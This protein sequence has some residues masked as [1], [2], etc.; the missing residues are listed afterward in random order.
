MSGKG[1]GFDVFL[2]H[3]SA[4]GR[5]V[6]ELAD[7]LRAR[8]LRPWLD[9]W[10]LVPGADWQDGLA[11]GLRR[12][13]S[14]AVFLGRSAL[15]SWQRPEVKVA[16]DRAAHD[17]SFRVFL[18]LLPGTPEPFDPTT[19][20]PFLR[21][22]TWVDLR[23]GPRAG[24]GLVDRLVRA[25]QGLPIDGPNGVAQPTGACPYRGLLPFGESDSQWF[26]GRDADVQRL[27]EKLK[28]SQFLAVLGPSGSGKSSVTMA[29]L[30]P[31]L[32][33][34]DVPGSH[35][36]AYVTLTPGPRPLESLVS[37]LLELRP[38]LPGPTVL[39]ELGASD[40]ALSLRLGHG[41]RRL[42]VT[43]DQA[44]EVFTLG[45]DR[46]TVE[47]FFGNLLH[48]SAPGGPCT[49]IL[50]MRADYY[51]RAATLPALAQTLG[52]HQYLVGPLDRDGLRQVI[53]QPALAAGLTLGPGLVDV[54]LDDVVDQ[55]GALPLLEHALLEVWERRQGT[56]LTVDAYTAT[57]GVRGALAARAEDIWSSFTGAEQDATK[58]LLLRLVQTA[59]GV[60]ATRRPAARS[61]ITTTAI[62][63]QDLDAVVAR[64]ASARLVTTSAGEAGTVELAHEALIRGWP[65]LRGWI[66]QG[67]DE[68]RTR[69]RISVAA[70]EWHQQPSA[71]LLWRGARLAAARE[72]ASARAGELNAREMAFLDASIG[73]E[74][75]EARRRRRRTVGVLGVIGVLLAAGT[76]VALVL[77]AQARRSEASA[78][79]SL[80][81]SEARRLA[82][83]SLRLLDTETDEALLLAVE[84]LAKSDTRE[85]RDALADAVTRPVQALGP[86]TSHG[87][88]VSGVAFDADAA[89][90]A[91]GGDDGVVRVW[92]AGQ[93]Q[94]TAALGEAGGPAVNGVAFDPATG[95]LAAAQRDGV[96]RLWDVTRREVVGELGSVGAP[97]VLTVAF[98]PGGGRLASATVDGIVQLWDLATME[99]REIMNV[100]TVEGGNVSALAFS[101]DG[102]RLAVAAGVLVAEW[103]LDA[104][105]LLGTGGGISEP[106]RTI[107]GVGY[108]SAGSLV[109][110]EGGWETGDVGLVL[111]RPPE[112][113]F[114]TWFETDE[115]GDGVVALAVNGEQLVAAGGSGDVR[116][117][118]AQDDLNRSGYQ[119]TSVAVSIDGS[120]VA[121]GT[122]QGHV[123]VWDVGPRR[124]L[125][126]RTHPVDVPA[127]AT[128]PGFV[129]IAVGEAAVALSHG[130]AIELLASPSLAPLGTIEAADHAS[131]FIG[132]VAIDHGG[133]FVAFTG[134]GPDDNTA[135]VIVV[136]AGSGEVIGQRETTTIAPVLAFRPGADV[137]AV[138]EDGSVLL[139]DWTTGATEAA[140]IE[141]GDAVF[142]LEFDDDGKLLAVATGELS[143]PGGNVDLYALEDGRPRRHDSFPGTAPFAW[144]GDGA[145]LVYDGDTISVRDVAAKTSSAIGVPVRPLDF[146]IDATSSHLV[147]A[148]VDGDLLAVDLAR[149]TPAGEAWVAHPIFIDETMD[150]AMSPDRSRVLSVG[151]NDPFV[152]EWRLPDRWIEAACDE[153][154]RNLTATEWSVYFPDESR[155]RTCEQFE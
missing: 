40:A 45:H 93:R 102:R 107:T 91:S 17:A 22:R 82:A 53:E 26:F 119:P 85:G 62:S 33:R 28:S 123:L 95:V 83:E 147:I 50:T 146:G 29:G 12:S 44:E 145:F 11:D 58:H 124:G 65:R 67:R 80:Q 129:S 103:D 71:D 148:T 122:E 104:G 68:L 120:L 98:D 31:A 90:L 118:F 75:A 34:G 73:H 144:A 52:A 16:L 32:R 76:V 27:I 153:V 24:G 6:G 25:V 112:Q 37:A 59:E 149:R 151:S 140:P 110:A 8:G 5:D 142:E 111:E 101:P 143:E 105:R 18:V 100:T 128:T 7:V 70:T 125:R 88:R 38:E 23:A 35:R 61:D 135:R 20:D 1:A 81:R 99:G 47:R 137:L 139:W 116:I 130:D 121:A 15:G 150:I 55:P 48:A 96:I 64:L 43:V 134:G 78:E 41:D 4:D 21:M 19:I 136:D 92:D 155:R 84:S 152:I 132:R 2:S 72:W 154:G 36:W 14:C 141:T 57:G 74:R 108:T 89:L 49:V 9:R 13:A 114:G 79:S 42:V 113:P 87:A 30:L 131:N 69:Q 94:E 77:F 106:S 109:V 54:V 3:D 97:S 10:E 56:L 133:R 60:D 117:P 127:D 115:F 138:G 51:A 46:L 86:V 66:E 63:E 39:S 126:E